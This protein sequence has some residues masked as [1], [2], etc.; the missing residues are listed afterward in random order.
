MATSERSDSLSYGA[1]SFVNVLFCNGEVCPLARG[2]D[3]VEFI[4]VTVAG[5]A[6][7]DEVSTLNQNLQILL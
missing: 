4:I 5:G 6:E 7:D 1:S 3:V 2:K